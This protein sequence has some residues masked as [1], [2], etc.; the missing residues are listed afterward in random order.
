M[1]KRTPHPSMATIMD[2]MSIISLSVYIGSLIAY[3]HHPNEGIIKIGIT[4]M[5]IWMGFRFLKP[6]EK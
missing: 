3:L 4:A 1:K 2:I 6:K 5:V